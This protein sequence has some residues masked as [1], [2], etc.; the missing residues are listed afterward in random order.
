MVTRSDT[1]YIKSLMCVGE[2]CEGEKERFIMSRVK[3]HHENRKKS[4][5]TDTT[6]QREMRGENYWAIELTVKENKCNTLESRNL[7]FSI[8]FITLNRASERE[9]EGERDNWTVNSSVHTA[10]TDYELHWDTE[11]HR[12]THEEAS[13]AKSNYIFVLSLRIYLSFYYSRGSGVPETYLL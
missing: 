10:H 13:K 11:R 12:D 1:H 7:L 8:N 5:R 6:F 9:R 3:S 2:R 4:H